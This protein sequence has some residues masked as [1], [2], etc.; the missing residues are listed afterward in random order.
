MCQV[1]LVGNVLLYLLVVWV[2]ER[3]GFPGRKA[4]IS[5]LTRFDK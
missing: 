2:M 4:D 1:P 5:I 3:L